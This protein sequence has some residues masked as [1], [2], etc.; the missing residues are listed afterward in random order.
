M[1]RVA[2]IVPWGILFSLYLIGIYVLGP[3]NYN[4]AV[5][6]YSSLGFAVAALLICQV[7]FFIMDVRRK[8]KQIAS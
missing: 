2:T 4:F 3:I 5:V 7:G 6:A 8:R 1:V